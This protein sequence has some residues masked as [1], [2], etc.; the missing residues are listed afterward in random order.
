MYDDRVSTVSKP[1][2]DDPAAAEVP[3]GARAT[4][5]GKP[6]RRRADAGRHVLAAG[7]RLAGRYRIL[8]FLAAGGMGEVY[9][10]WD[11][12]LNEKIALKTL[13]ADL[14]DDRHVERFRSEIQL[15]RKVTHPNVCRIFDLGQHAF[16]AGDA[17][18]G[19]PLLFLTME[20]IEGPTL[21][22]RLGGRPLGLDE[23]SRIVA[24]M[25]AALAAAHESGVIHRDFKSSN[26]LLRV[27]GDSSRGIRAVVT[28]FGLALPENAG[29]ADADQAIGTPEYMAPEQLRGEPL[30]PACD[31]YAL[32]VVMF[33]MVTGELPFPENPYARLQ[34]PPPS[35]RALRPELPERWERTI[36]RCLEQDPADRFASAS[37]VAAA[38]GRGRLPPS[39]SRARL[40]RTLAV[41]AAVASLVAMAVAIGAAI[42]LRARPA[43]TVA[44]ASAPARPATRR[45]RTVAVLGF[46]NLSGRA[47][48]AWLSTALGEM[49]ATEIAAGADLRV[50]PPDNIARM[51]LEM[52]LRDGDTLTV[53]TLQR[54]RDRVAADL[55]ADGSYLVLREPGGGRIRLDLRLQETNVGETVAAASETARDSELFE[56]VSRAGDRLREQLGAPR[57]A[58]DEAGGIR[59]TLPANA[60]AARFYVEGLTRL[61]RLDALAAR[62]LLVKAAAIEP[63][64]PFVHSALSSAWSALGY[65][66]KAQAEAKLAFDLSGRLSRADRLGIEARYRATAP[67]WDQAIRIYR[68]LFSFF[69]DDLEYGLRLAQAET[70]AGHGKDALA[71]LALLRQ[72]PPPAGEDPSID[73]AEALAAETL[74]DFK[75]E[76]AAAA[77]AAKRG[78]AQGARLLV[79]RA[80]IAE[81]V[82]LY[83]LADPKAAMAAYTEAQR[84]ALDAGDRVG[85][86]RA[87]Q[88]IAT[89]RIQRG[90]VG[91]K[92]Q[93]EEALAIYREIGDRRGEAGVL[94]GIATIVT[95]EDPERAVHLYEQA[96][97]TDRLIG[98]KRRIAVELNNLAV[99]YEQQRKLAPAGKNYQESARVFREA[100]FDSAAGSALSNLAAN[101]LN[102]GD[103]DSARESADEALRILRP[104]DSQPDIAWALSV[105]S[106]VLIAADE[107]EPARRRLEQA[108]AICDKLGQPGDVAAIQILLATLALDEGRPADA[109]RL[110]RAAVDQ[111]AAG[112]SALNQAA[113][114][115]VGAEALSAARKPVEAAAALGR[116]RALQPKSGVDPDHALTLTLATARV[117]A[118]AGE[119][120]AA[121]ATLRSG[122]AAARHDGYVLHQLQLRLALAA[123]DA[124]DAPALISEARGRGL[125]HLARAAAALP[126]RR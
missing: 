84:I 87:L 48:D 6:R 46:K 74:S 23:A 51:K 62:D 31:L 4:V 82:A 52:G 120:A 98:D 25:A 118:G 5:S 50:I 89:L 78:S 90:D 76:R 61:R 71:T 20:L 58:K 26:V 72:L 122:L 88:Q 91:A 33:E 22:Q 109:E 107:V 79:E 93:F 3:G 35:P 100:G 59:A 99:S 67:D 80:R 34:Q 103:V 16:A 53:P 19:G 112:S 96:L 1:T 7:E 49:L 11:E 114:W 95:D 55:V 28:D 10:A 108:S 8:E 15:A 68:A 81:G 56:I 21:A 85:V 77:A 83:S 69:P 14:F 105:L 102:R 75:R 24:Q 27:A 2:T 70:Q 57:V 18:A 117:H 9:A 45:R 66:L 101:L 121:L 104:T 60:E 94:S 124:E 54:V 41:A 110:A 29:H 116:A 125:M 47:E 13:V 36:G 73:L 43:P 40:Q 92:R 86:A 119:R 115:A 113:A 44:A 38:I 17:R 42:E 126:A 106:Q 32:G 65:D 63:K 39:R 30:T 97:A 64:H 37:D 12:A 123:L 111:A